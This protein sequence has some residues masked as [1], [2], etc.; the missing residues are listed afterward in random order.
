VEDTN[1][2]YV[3]IE[4]IL[5]KYKPSLSRSITGEEAIEY[6]KTHNDIDL[7]LMD[8]QLPGRNGYETTSIIREFNKNIP[9]IAQ[10]AY[11]MYDDVVKAL[12]AGCNDFL[13][14]L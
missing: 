3:L 8:I 9:I 11:A 10:T 1:E 6:L 2:N 14:N 5:R 12:D 4:T 13:P 7:V